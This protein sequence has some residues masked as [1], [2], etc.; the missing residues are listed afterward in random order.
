MAESCS[1]VCLACVCC[2]QHRERHKEIIANQPVAVPT[3]LGA[4]S[5][6][7]HQLP[8]TSKKDLLDCDVL[9][10]CANCTS[11]FAPGSPSD[12]LA[13]LFG[14][15]CGYDNQYFRELT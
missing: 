9:T 10:A 1:R 12:F 3:H 2:A 13:H 4:F 7:S 15:S 8:G 5:T 6:G 11:S 14:V